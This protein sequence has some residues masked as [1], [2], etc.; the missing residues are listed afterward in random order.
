MD[1]SPGWGLQ[2]WV[3]LGVV[4]ALHLA[5][6]A[7]LMMVPAFRQHSS[8]ADQPIELVYLPPAT[9]PKIR[10]NNFRPQR[11]SGDTALSIAPPTLDAVAPMLSPSASAG[12]GHGA[13]V[14]WNAE[15]RRAVQAIE[16]RTRHPPNDNTIPV[17]PLEETWWPRRHAGGEFK[18]A[19][20]DWIVWI[21]SSCYQVATNAAAAPALG[22]MLPPTICTRDSMPRGDMQEPRPEG[23]EQRPATN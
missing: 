4:L 6:F 22:A 15:A 11:L 1:Q 16:I 10:P 23:E 3:T 14:D 2:R 18:T 13:G 7:A 19:G 9:P 20:G 8:S 5:L 17:S 21:N 12:Q